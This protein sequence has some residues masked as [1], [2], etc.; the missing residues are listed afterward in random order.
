MHDH[1]QVLGIHPGASADDVKAAYH[2][3]MRSVHPDRRPGDHAAAERARQANAAWQVLRSES[4]RTA[5]DVARGHRAPP[6]RPSPESR[7]ATSVYSP[8]QTA[9]RRAFSAACLRVAAAV[10][11]AGFALLLVS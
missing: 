3:I 2:R 10:F 5:Y 8:E 6:P 11:V 4:R 7:R 9:Y 1:Y